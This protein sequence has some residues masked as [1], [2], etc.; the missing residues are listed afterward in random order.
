MEVSDT[1]LNIV[2]PEAQGQSHI[3]TQIVDQFIKHI[4]LL[5][6]NYYY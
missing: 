5:L 1:T 2:S 3:R 6:L 4:N